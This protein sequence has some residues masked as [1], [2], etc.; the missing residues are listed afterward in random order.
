MTTDKPLSEL[1]RR[2]IAEYCGP[3]AGIGAAAAKAAGYAGSGATLAVQANRLLSK[4]KVQAEIAKFRQQS[5]AE[6]ILTAEECG[7]MLSG[8]ATGLIEEPAPEGG[9]QK[10]KIADRIKALSV[11]AKIRGYEAATKTELS[12]TVGVVALTAEQAEALDVW[13][14]VRDDPRVIAVIEE[15]M[16]ER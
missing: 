1:E 12:G 4:A 5:Q 2:F 6:G 3:S 10:A 9:T 11:L 15:R 13:L 7:T 16:E 14:L 8:Y